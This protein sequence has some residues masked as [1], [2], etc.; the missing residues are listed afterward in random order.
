M[1]M[2]GVALAVIDMAPGMNVAA[3]GIVDAAMGMN[4]AAAGRQEFHAWIRR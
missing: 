3:V 1:G 2:F 4:V